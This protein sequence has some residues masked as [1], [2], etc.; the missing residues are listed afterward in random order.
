MA[1]LPKRRSRWHVA[2]LLAGLA[3][4]FPRASHA[5][6]HWDAALQAG[7]E[8]RFLDRPDGGP[9]AGF[10]PIAQVSVH[11][12]LIP[13]V[14]VGGYFGHHVSPT[15]G[16]ASTRQV[17]FG[18]LRFKGMVPWVRGSARAWIFSGFGYS[19]AYAPSYR[20]PTP[21]ILIPGA[22]PYRVEGA[23]G[24]FFE[25]PFGIGASYKV[26]KPWELFAELGGRA[27]FGHSG[28]LYEPGPRYAGYPSGPSTLIEGRAPAGL[29]LFAVGLTVGALVDF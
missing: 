4:L 8:K 10:G 15:D 26:Y 19:G 9:N 17:T 7:V 24:S 28:T 3:F 21:T 6:L 23:G 11:V 27:G 14:R 29:D 1:E 2:V 16:I 13:L 25:V 20:G 12:A 22:T 18:G 5:Q